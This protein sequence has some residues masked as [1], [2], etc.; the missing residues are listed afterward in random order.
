[1]ANFQSVEIGKKNFKG[2]WSINVEGTRIGHIEKFTLHREANSE[3]WVYGYFDGSPLYQE[4]NSFLLGQFDSL[5]EAKTFAR[6]S[7]STQEDF[8]IQ[9]VKCL[10]KFIELRV[11][12]K[13]TY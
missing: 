3:Y 10:T 12:S 13:K 1:M 8:T 11:F 9:M 5:K 4:D 2:H 7:L 6:S